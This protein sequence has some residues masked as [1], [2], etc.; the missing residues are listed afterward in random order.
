MASQRELG[1]HED[2]AHDR[3]D[4]DQI[5]SAVRRLRASS[6]RSALADLAEAKLRA[7]ENG[8]RDP[9]PADSQ[10]AGA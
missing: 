2:T 7:I 6:P 5:R 4:L 3:P 8:G 1:E 10:R 9:R